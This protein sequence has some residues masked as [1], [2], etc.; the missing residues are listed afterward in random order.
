MVEAV[1]QGDTMCQK[2]VFDNLHT[3]RYGKIA[4]KIITNERATKIPSK[5]FASLATQGRVLLLM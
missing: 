3:K 1:L 2:S 4:S 5:S